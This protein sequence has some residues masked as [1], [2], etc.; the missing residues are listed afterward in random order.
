MAFVAVLNT[1]ALAQQHIKTGPSFK[2]R[3][4]VS[5]TIGLPG[6]RMI[7]VLKPERVRDLTILRTPEP[8]S[9]AV[10]VGTYWACSEGPGGFDECDLRIVVCDDAGEQCVELP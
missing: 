5:R 4:D 8:I 9:A 10:S 1:P 3:T 7:A 6:D 2:D